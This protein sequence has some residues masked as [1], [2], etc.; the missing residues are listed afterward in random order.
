[1]ETNNSEKEILEEESNTDINETEQEAQD[2][3]SEEEKDENESEEE[4]SSFAD[5]LAESKDKY[6]RLYSEFENFRRRTAKEKRDLISSANKDLLEDILP[7]LDDFERA[8]TSISDLAS[9]TEGVKLI[10]TKLDKVLTS[11]GLKKMELEKG[12]E[13]DEE[14]HEAIT[15]IH[16]EEGME[17]KIVDVVEAGYML[18]DKV[19]RFAKVVV[20]ANQ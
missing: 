14:F 4:E 10:L 9:F 3:T 17:G 5:E 20:G 19:V 16:A 13:F 8:L 2:T 12:S 15:Q 11:K 7:V 18:G 6:I 1:M